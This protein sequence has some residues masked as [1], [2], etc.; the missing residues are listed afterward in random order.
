MNDYDELPRGDEPGA[1]PIEI[2]DNFNGSG[3]H[4]RFH[5]EWEREGDEE[6]MRLAEIA[7]GEC[8]SARTDAAYHDLGRAPYT[9][10]CWRCSAE[11]AADAI[12]CPQCWAANANHDFEAACREMQ[13][14]RSHA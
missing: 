6:L 12:R 1:Y 10:L 2:G 4:V 5:R 3:R 9:T 13:A 8:M 11:Y 7:R 14:E